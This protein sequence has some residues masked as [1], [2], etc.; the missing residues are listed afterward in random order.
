MVKYEKSIQ[1]YY[2]GL[3]CDVVGLVD[4]C[5]RADFHGGAFH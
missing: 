3:G 1:I 5:W 2:G 4:C